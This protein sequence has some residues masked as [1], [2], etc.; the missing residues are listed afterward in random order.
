MQELTGSLDLKKEE[1][2]RS[3]FEQA[4]T[5]AMM[6][7]MSMQTCAAF[8]ELS[9]RIQTLDAVMKLP[10]MH[11]SSSLETIKHAKKDYE[12]EMRE[13]DLAIKMLSSYPGIPEA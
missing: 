2:T 1:M 11:M 8:E 3:P 4:Q 9:T 7:I 10:V 13:I 5:N 6:F 12:R